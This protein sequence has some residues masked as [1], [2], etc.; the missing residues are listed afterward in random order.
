MTSTTALSMDS[1]ELAQVVASLASD[2]KIDS[3]SILNVGDL[4]SLCDHF[5]IV[6]AGN[7]RLTTAVSRHI[8]DELRTRNIM[9]TAVEGRGGAWV[10]MDFSD[11]IVHIFFEGARQY[12]DLEGFWSDAPRAELDIEA[13][14]TILNALPKKSA[15]DVD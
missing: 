4:S 10:L 15:E 5:V 3:V 6:A 11:V 7:P 9:P 13:G 12:Y 2:K 1:L 8:E 14:A